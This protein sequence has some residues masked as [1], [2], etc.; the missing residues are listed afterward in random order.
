MICK[1][2][3]YKKAFASYNRILCALAF[4]LVFITLTACKGGT[5]EK[6]VASAEVSQAS[7]TGRSTAVQ[8]LEPAK[9]SASIG[10][11]VINIDYSNSSDGYIIVYYTGDSSKTKF[12]LTGSDQVTYTYN[13]QTGQETVLPLSS[14]SGEY[15]VTLFES[16]GNDQY[17]TSFSDVISVDLQNKF[18]PFLYP[19]QY[20]N[21]TKDTIAVKKAAELV[22]GTTCELEA[23][24][25]VY[26]YVVDNVVYDKEEA[27]NVE[28]S[29]LPSVDEVLSTGKGICFDYAAL[30][31]AMLRSQGI[32]T[33][34]EIGYAKDAYHAWIS[35]YTKDQGWIGGVIQFDGTNWTLMDPT[36][37]ANTKDASAIKNFIGDGSSYTTKYKY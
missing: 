29:Y 4:V 3:K 36:L 6:N 5:E 21:F 19:N 23:V 18:G 26:G 34:L 27:E 2:Y 32:P 33:R 37:A 1:D 9:G 16:L 20:V 8:V 17:S 30:M 28:S 24:S 22:S 11:D 15:T 7:T 13:L 31:A 25:K 10:N 35:V 14:D 12:Q